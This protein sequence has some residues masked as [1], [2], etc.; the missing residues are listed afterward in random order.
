MGPSMQ[1]TFFGT[2][3]QICASTQSCLR[4]L[5]TIPS[6]LWLGFCSDMHCQMWDLILTGV[7]LSKSCPIYHR[8]TPIKL[9]KQLKDDQWINRMHLS[10]I[11][12]LIAKGLNTYVNKDF[13]NIHLRTF[14]KTCLWGIACRLLSIFKIHFVIRL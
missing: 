4:A 11:S 14:L 7:Y 8:W 12:S 9:K 10:S 2:L 3:P 6:T 5:G 13:F 1:L